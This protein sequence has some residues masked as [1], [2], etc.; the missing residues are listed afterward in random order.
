MIIDDS[1]L[2]DNQAL[3]DT[4]EFTPP[5][6]EYVDTAKPIS[7]GGPPIS[8]EN[9]PVIQFLAQ[10]SDFSFTIPAGYEFEQIITSN[11]NWEVIRSC[12]LSI[13]LGSARSEVLAHQEM[14][15]NSINVIPINKM[16]SFTADTTLYMGE[17][18]SP[19]T[20]NDLAFDI[21]VI[22]KKIA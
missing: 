9:N 6:N 22:L 10:G 14:F 20:W 18:G 1:I 21:Y 16:F 12:Y 15:C 2:L 17:A 3:T 4:G 19:D 8:I 13:G 5:V 11:T 7:S